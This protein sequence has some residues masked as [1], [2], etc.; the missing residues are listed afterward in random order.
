MADADFEP[1]DEDFERLMQEAF[2][3]VPAT[4]QKVLA[5][6][7]DEIATVRA[8]AEELAEAAVRKAESKA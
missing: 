1:T 2:A 8:M 6:F 7:W 3:D 5:C 4:N